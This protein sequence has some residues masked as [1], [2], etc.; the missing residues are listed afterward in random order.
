[1]NRFIVLIGIFAF[2][3]VIAI[4]EL[5][6][7]S[8]PISPG[9]SHDETLVTAT[10]R[11][12][13]DAA[14]LLGEIDGRDPEASGARGADDG[15]LAA[16]VK[17]RDDAATGRGTSLPEPAKPDDAAELTPP[18]ATMRSLRVVSTDAFDNLV[19]SSIEPAPAAGPAPITAVPVPRPA[20]EPAPSPDQ[21]ARS[22]A[23]SPELK[24]SHPAARKNLAAR[25]RATV[26]K[27]PRHASVSSAT[28]RHATHRSVASDDP[29]LRLEREALDFV[30]S[31]LRAQRRAL[32]RGGIDIYE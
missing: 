7:R 16:I 12:S 8:A 1:M 29:S 24:A 2:V 21:T 10:D 27:A 9:P 20:L 28:R 18:D 17:E 25:D 11:A 19:T 3:A 5:V 26:E 32:G 15:I 22:S 4:G 31:V 6:D 30:E 13:H 14:V 23:V